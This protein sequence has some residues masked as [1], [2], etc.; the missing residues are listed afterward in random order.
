MIRT[1]IVNPISVALI[2]IG[3]LALVKKSEKTQF[4]S[5]LIMGMFTFLF[6][7]IGGQ[8]YTYYSLIFSSFIPIGLLAV[9][10]TLHYHLFAGYQKSKKPKVS[11]VFHVMHRFW[12]GIICAGCLIFSFTMCNNTYLLRYK[13]SDLPQYQFAKIIAQKKDATLLNY[14]FLD[15]GFY[16]TTGIIPNCKFFCSVNIALD[17]MTEM[18]NEFVNKGQV[19]FVITRNSELESERYECIATSTFYFEGSEWEYFLY[20]L[21]H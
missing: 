21:I 18:Q 12:A 5:Y 9:S 4:V 20:Q 3:M 17:E 6:V 7:Y 1:F 14:G 15:G 16:T 19:D 8:N 2:G 11:K 10:Q 13:K